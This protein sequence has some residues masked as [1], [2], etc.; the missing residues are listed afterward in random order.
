M[1]G[2]IGRDKECAKFST[3]NEFLF[4]SWGCHKIACLRKED[5]VA[6]F[7]YCPEARFMM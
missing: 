4:K 6:F 2:K 1:G 5:Q 3:Q 7:D